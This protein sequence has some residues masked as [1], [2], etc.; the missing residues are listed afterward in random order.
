MKDK[1]THSIVMLLLPCERDMEQEEA[2]MRLK[3]PN[4]RLA[5]CDD[6]LVPS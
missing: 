2:E 4:A 1:P 3:E 5:F 6:S